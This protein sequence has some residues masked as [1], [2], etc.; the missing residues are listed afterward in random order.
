MLIILNLKSFPSYLF[1][2]SSIHSEHTVQTYLRHEKGHEMLNLIWKSM[3]ISTIIIK[4]RIHGIICSPAKSYIGSLWCKMKE[5]NI[6]WLEYNLWSNNI[7]KCSYHEQLQQQ[8]QQ[9]Q[10]GRLLLDLNLEPAVW[11]AGRLAAPSGGRPWILPAELVLSLVMA[12]ILFFSC[13]E[14]TEV[15]AIPMS[16]EDIMEFVSGGAGDPT[17]WT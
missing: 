14:L 17:S 8:H 12:T 13:W 3:K 5:T 2:C 1:F 7:C 10:H 11:P 6:S 4:K 15:M 9:K 16:S